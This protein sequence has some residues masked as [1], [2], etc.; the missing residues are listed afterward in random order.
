M[1]NTKENKSLGTNMNKKSSFDAA[2]AF[3]GTIAALGFMIALGA[4][5]QMDYNDAAKSEN[6]ELGYEKNTITNKNTIPEAL[7]GMLLLGVG[8]IGIKS[9]TAQ[10][11]R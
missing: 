7:V 8:A 1:E 2:K 3:Y 6:Q 10:K 9:R 4:A 11:T 5:G